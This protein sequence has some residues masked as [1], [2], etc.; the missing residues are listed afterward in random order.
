MKFLVPFLIMTSVSWG[1]WAAESQ[2]LFDGQP[3]IEIEGIRHALVDADDNEPGAWFETGEGYCHLMGWGTM[4]SS[5]S[6]P[7]RSAPL[8]QLKANG[9]VAKIYPNNAARTLWVIQQITCSSRE[10]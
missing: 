1:A 8:A 9:E 2:T 6:S 5:T 4:T 10:N 7:L 3:S